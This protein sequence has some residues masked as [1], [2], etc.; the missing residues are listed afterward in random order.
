MVTFPRFEEKEAKWHPNGTWHIDGHIHPH[1]LDSKDPA[2]IALML[3]SDVEPE[4]GGTALCEGSHLVATQILV[5]SGNEGL[6]SKELAQRVMNSRETFNIIEVT[7]KAGDV[8]LMHPLMLHA[9]STNLSENTIRILCHP[10]I[11]LKQPMNFNKELKDLSVLERSIVYGTL[12]CNSSKIGTSSW[13][14]D[15]FLR[16]CDSEEFIN[17]LN[18]PEQ[19]DTLS[20]AQKQCKAALDLLRDLCSLNTSIEQEKISSLSNSKRVKLD[21]LHE[22]SIMEETSHVLGD[23]HTLDQWETLGFESF[24]S[25][26]KW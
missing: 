10:S 25:T 8:I 21:N 5:E 6:S 4:G 18:A 9:R 13:T 7:G 19:I 1:Y 11:S 24:K 17:P 16:M 15:E 12:C 3:F 20:Y 26:Y 23:D 22:I 2:L 14:A